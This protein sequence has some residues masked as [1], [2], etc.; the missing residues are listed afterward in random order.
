M[1]INKKKLICAMTNADMTSQKLANKVGMSVTQVSNI[2]RGFGTTYETALKISEVLN[3]S[4]WDL[5]DE[6]R[7]EDHKPLT[8]KNCGEEMNYDEEDDYELSDQF[9][10]EWR[11]W[12]WNEL[13][14]INAKLN[15]IMEA[16]DIEVH[17]GELG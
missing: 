7:K 5:V 17:V 15:K 3:V 12:D 11:Q 13:R 6:D 9:Y 8:N 1:K 14:V 16:L 4:I 10:W 2:R